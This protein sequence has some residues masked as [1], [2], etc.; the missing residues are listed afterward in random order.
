LSKYTITTP[1]ADNKAAIEIGA[2]TLMEI[3]VPSEGRR[4]G[5]GHP[6]GWD[7]TLSTTVATPVPLGN[8]WTLHPIG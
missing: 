2:T 1:K 6:T 7:G 3:T 4:S 8:N 5:S